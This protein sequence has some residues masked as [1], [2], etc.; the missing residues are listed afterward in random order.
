II[1]FAYFTIFI[2]FLNGCVERDGNITANSNRASSANPV[3]EAAPL[4][5]GK[6]NY[7]ILTDDTLKLTIT[8]DGA[9]QAEI[10]YQ[11]IV[12]SDRSIK[13]R[14]VNEKNGNSFVTE[15]KP[16]QD[17]NGEVW[18]RVKYSNGETKQTERLLLS[19]RFDSVGESDEQQANA[20]NSSNSVIEKGN[21]GDDDSAR[22]DKATGGRIEKAQ[23]EP[24]KGK[25]RITLNVPAFELTLWQDGKEVGVYPVG[26]GRKEFPIPIGERRAREII[27]NPEW[28]PPDSEWVRESKNVEP[29]ERI[30]AG[31]PD[32]PLGKIK[33]PL[34][35]AYLLHEAQAP[36][37]LG[38][39]VSHGCVRILRNDIFEL[40][41]KIVI[42]RGISDG[43]NKIEQSQNDTVRRA[44]N[45]GEPLTVDIN[46]DTMVVEGG[47][48]FI[49]PDVY[50]RK[51]NTVENLRAELESYKIDVSKLD[52]KTLRAMLDKATDKQQFS[53][54]L[55]DIRAGNALQKGKTEPLVRQQ[56]RKG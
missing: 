40:A 36:S 42:A 12:A 28:I 18:A 53:V 25:I 20:N 55:E 44:I 17:F 43:E 56:E 3:I 32:N 51:T 22:S 49:Y 50:D 27:L 16:P 48:L 41:K 34:G 35:D 15:I 26:V 29:Y 19:A 37:D 24:G 2:M 6:G 13:L 21:I 38:N 45:L 11:P 54:S 23:V 52:E 1:R 33:F 9:I 4:R 31:D 8:A 30:P 7:K 46:Y 47:V 14:T 39:L 10:Y 5:P